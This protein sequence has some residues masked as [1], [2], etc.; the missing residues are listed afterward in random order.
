MHY[1]NAAGLTGIITNNCLWASH[2]DFLNDSTEMTHFFDERLPELIE[3][4]IRACVLNHLKEDR[5]FAN[6]LCEF[7]GVESYI[8]S[9][10]EVMVKI[11]RVRT[12]EFN[13]PYIFSTSQ[14]CGR[15]AQSGLLSQWR[16]YG[17]DGGYAL[18]FDLVKL[19]QLLGIEGKSF[20]YGCIFGGD[21]YYHGADDNCS[22]SE[23]IAELERIVCDV[24]TRWARQ[25]I[26]E[27]EE[28]DS[29]EKFVKMADPISYLSC[30]YKHVG[31]TEEREYR[32]V[33]M[34]H[35]RDDPLSPERMELESKPIK[36]FLRRGLPVPYIE[37]GKQSIGLAKYVPLPITR[38]IVGPHRDA[39]LR[40]GAVKKLLEAHG[41][42]AVEVVRS[43][44]PYIGQ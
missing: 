26:S 5:D 13:N 27:E 18:I 8:A 9:E 44:I 30:F 22:C 7:R 19:Q 33:M 31:F 37:L 35:R 40:V 10:T 21:V 2:A 32:F 14:A 41:H 17:V 34:P 1:T 24:I 23:E 25:R 43:A 36:T 4:K 16:G 3:P 28:E 11:L 29:S 15:V 6:K 38:I 39:E 42:G 20:R 12:L